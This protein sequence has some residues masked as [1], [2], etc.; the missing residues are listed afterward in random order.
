MATTG[1]AIA[2]RG[3]A[4]D[5][6][7][8]EVSRPKFT[9]QQRLICGT[10]IIG[11]VFA[12]YMYLML[13]LIIGPA[14]SELLGAPPG[15]PAMNLWV[16][17]MF[18]IPAVCGGIFGLL[19]GYM[20][21]R[22]GRLKVLVGSILLYGLS[23]VASGFATSM[24]ALL[25]F[26]CGIFVGVAVE[27]VAAITWLAELFPDQKQREAAIGYTQAAQSFGGY[28]VAEAY[29]LSV[30][31]AHNLPAVNGVQEGWRYTMLTGL[32]PVVII[33]ALA[34]FLPESRVWQEKKRAGTLKRPSLVELFAPGFLRT[35]LCTTIMM[36]CVFGAASGAIQQM[37]RVVPSVPEMQGV[38]RTVQQQT[39]GTVAQYQEV[40]GIVGRFLLA[41]LASRIISRRK[42]LWLFQVPGL[43]ILPF[44]FLFAPT[45][46]AIAK[47]GIFFV[48]FTTISQLSFWGNYL[49]GAFPTYLRGTGEGFAANVG[50]RMVGNTIALIT[51]SLIVSMPGANPGT[52]LAYAAGLVGTSVYIISFIT[53]FWLP[54]PKHR[55]ALHE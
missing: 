5:T 35:T 36:A 37:P 28:L 42:L 14:A 24:P 32:I 26:R 17:R 48:A 12:I 22:I 40:G 21:D 8:A 46:L 9:G 45:S 29:Y 47:W 51:T 49:P 18:W 25:I 50:G 39:V 15:S 7:V 13:P 44:V 41:F 19:G 52:K 16:G 34:P 4:T 10:A 38:D 54:E 23:A 31:H 1:S 33:L 20:I 11:F 6:A 30:T 43:F 27:F 53:S 55:E 3:S 2:A